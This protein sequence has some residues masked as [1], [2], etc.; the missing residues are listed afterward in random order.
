MQDQELDNKKE[1][2]VNIVNV[3]VKTGLLSTFFFCKIN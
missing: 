2:I 3:E 1:L